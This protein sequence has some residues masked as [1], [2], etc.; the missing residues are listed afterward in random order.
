VGRPDAAYALLQKGIERN[1]ENWRLV[2]EYGFHRYLET[3][4]SEEASLYLSR[5]A[6]MPGAPDWVARLAAYAATES[7]ES[8]LALQLWRQVLR[9]SANEEI[10]RIARR[11]LRTLGAPEASSFPP[12]DAAAG[13]EG[14]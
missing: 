12:D 6:A 4:R 2:F 5:A 14:R 7:G 8:D 9:S 3:K 13:E 10:R 11:Y 1:P